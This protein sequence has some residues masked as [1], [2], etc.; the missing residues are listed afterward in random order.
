MPEQV[1]VCPYC[2]GTYPHQ[3][4][5]GCRPIEWPPPKLT[6]DPDAVASILASLS[7]EQLRAAMTRVA[8][9]SPS[10]FRTV[11]KEVVRTEPCIHPGVFAVDNQPY[12]YCW[13]CRRSIPREQL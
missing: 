7:P 8:E 5:T 2:Q 1:S 11:T 9:L 12:T 10:T 4:P 6:D 3:A 13:T